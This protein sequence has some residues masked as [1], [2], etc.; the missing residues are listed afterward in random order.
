MRC[1]SGFKD[2]ESG[3]YRCRA[4]GGFHSHVV[5]PIVLATLACATRSSG[6][7][8][9]RERHEVRRCRCLGKE[10]MPRND[11]RNDDDSGDGDNNGNDN[12]EGE[13]E[14]DDDEDE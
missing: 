10:N 4:H 11:H 6:V 7:D 9:K 2:Q 13:E 5:V 14:D 1:T 12:E 8:R 3:R